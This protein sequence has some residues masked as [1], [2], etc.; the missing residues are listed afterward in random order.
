MF[1][2]A[3]RRR[4]SPLALGTCV[5]FLLSFA[6]LGAA[7]GQEEAPAGVVPIEESSDSPNVLPPSS[8]ESPVGN[9]ANARAPFADFVNSP[10]TP[11]SLPNGANKTGVSSQAISVPQGP[12][13]I[14]G[15]GE[16]FST[17]LSTGTGTA[18]LPFALPPARGDAQPSLAL[19]YSS[20]AGHGVGGIGWSLGIPFIARQTDR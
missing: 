15:M 10:D 17:Q 11:M 14:Q 1:I 5:C 18:A 4:S 3:L 8:D 19:S 16:S 6:P 7:Q 12:G 13:K 20:G 2:R 9:K